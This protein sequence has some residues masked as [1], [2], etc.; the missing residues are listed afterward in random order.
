MWLFTPF[1]RPLPLWRLVL[2]YLIPVIPLLVSWD[3]LIS[4]LRSYTRDELSELC[5]GLVG[6]RYRW[7]QGGAW[8]G[9]QNITWLIGYPDEPAVTIADEAGPALT[10]SAGSGPSPVSGGDSG[11]RQRN[12]VPRPGSLSTPT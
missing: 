5:D 2:T 8:K 9:L 12:V 11:S 6:P 10:A 1:V 3:G 7:V 4:T